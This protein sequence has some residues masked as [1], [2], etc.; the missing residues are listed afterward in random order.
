LEYDPA[1]KTDRYGRLLAYLYR[2]PD[3]LNVNLEIIRQGYGHA[4]LSY[5]H[6]Y[7]D[8][9]REMGRRARMLNKGLYAE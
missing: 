8:D 7:L 5:P 2:V 1:N 3:G 6:P 4:L 9:Y